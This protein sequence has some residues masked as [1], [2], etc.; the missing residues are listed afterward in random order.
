MTGGK[1]VCADASICLNCGRWAK[2]SDAIEHKWDG[3]GGEDE[4]HMVVDHVD[5][6]DDGP[7][8]GIGDPKGEAD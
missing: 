2:T 4:E 1:L 3:D 6:V 5:I 8:D 7:D